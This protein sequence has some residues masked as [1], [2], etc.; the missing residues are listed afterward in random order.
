MYAKKK[1]NKVLSGTGKKKIQ[2]YV[3]KR[4]EVYRKALLKKYPTLTKYAKGTAARADSWKATNKLHQIGAMTP[5][6]TYRG[7]KSSSSTLYPHHT[8]TA[9]GVG[10]DANSRVPKALAELQDDNFFNDT[11]V[12]GHVMNADFGGIGS[13]A[14][15]QTIL[16][17]DANSAHKNGWESPVKKA[18][19]YMSMVVRNLRALELDGAQEKIV[20]KIESDWR[21]ELNGVVSADSWWDELSKADRKKLTKPRAKIVKAISTKLNFTAVAV[22]MPTDTQLQELKINP[23]SG[24]FWTVVEYLENFKQMMAQVATFQLEQTPDGFDKANVKSS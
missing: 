17:S 11:F 16:T 12:S 2:A 23:D 18:Q 21:I 22:G 13:N 8:A 20:D 24:Q 4:R 6:D 19:Y 3:E 14:G 7:S 5:F 15:N 10:T 1:I 9:S